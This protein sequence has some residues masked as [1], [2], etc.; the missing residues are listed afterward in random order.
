MGKLVTLTDANFDE[1]VLQSDKPVLVDFWAE[2]CQPCHMIAPTVE[3]LSND[4]DGQVKVGKMD[5]DSNQ[6][7][8]SKYQIMSIP[9]LLIYNNGEVVERITGVVPKEHIAGL[10]DKHSK[11]ELT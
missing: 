9:S 7:T 6:G 5:I 1:E 4:Y 8:A 11:A 2:W 3:E 10:L